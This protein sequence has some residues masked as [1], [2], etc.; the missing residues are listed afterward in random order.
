VTPDQ[1][2]SSSCVNYFGKCRKHCGV[3]EKSVG[4]IV[5][6]IVAKTDDAETLVRKKME[7]G[8]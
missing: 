8:P 2:D 7:I 4:N 5:A 6:T 1:V 3:S